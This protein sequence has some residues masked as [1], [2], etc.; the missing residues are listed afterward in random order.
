MAS[1]ETQKNSQQTPQHFHIFTTFHIALT[2]F[3]RLFVLLRRMPTVVTLCITLIIRESNDQRPLNP[4]QKLTSSTEY[5][6]YNSRYF[7]WILGP[8]VSDF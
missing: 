8:T 7:N 6:P 5:T 2:N 1:E 3:P 4:H